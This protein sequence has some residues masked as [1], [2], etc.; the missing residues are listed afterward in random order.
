MLQIRKELLGVFR[1]IMSITNIFLYAIIA[2]LNN[3]ILIRVF[4]EQNF[5]KT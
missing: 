4:L 1:H 3:F 2:N 5:A